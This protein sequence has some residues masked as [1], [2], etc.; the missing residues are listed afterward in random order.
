[1]QYPP[2]N[3]WNWYM[4]RSEMSADNKTNHCLNA[5]KGIGC[6]G[7]VFIHVMFPGK[8]GLAIKTLARFAVPLFFMTSGYYLYSDKTEV[9]QKRLPKKI[10][11]TVVLAVESIAVYLLY[12][13]IVHLATG[14][15]AACKEWFHAVFNLKYAVRIILDNNLTRFGAGPLW[16]L[17]ALIWCYVLSAALNKMGL[18]K[19]AYILIPVLLLGRVVVIA[20][21]GISDYTGN[22]VFS[23][24]PYFFV[25]Y[26]A[27]KYIN[28]VVKVRKRLILVMVVTAA[29]VSVVL[30]VIHAPAYRTELF[31]IIYA[32]A[33]FA[34]TL[35]SPDSLQGTYLEKIGGGVLYWGICIPFPDLV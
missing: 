35:I 27:A 12:A 3:L 2:E 33:A 7:V 20:V 15:S 25:G 17:L 9:V 30:A 18:I 32:L 31:V 34:F 8:F 6:I 21:T 10:Q 16:F 24:L 19:H 14:S 13:V 4:K 5:L 1:M 28:V 22:F 11:R 26:F 23:G 29:V